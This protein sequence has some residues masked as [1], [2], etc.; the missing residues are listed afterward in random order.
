MSKRNPQ[1]DAAGLL[2]SW[3]WSSFMVSIPG[4]PTYLK[5]MLRTAG[6]AK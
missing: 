3:A 4:I 5:A 2:A 1:T 6:E